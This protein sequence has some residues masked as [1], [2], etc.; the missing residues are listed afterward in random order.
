MTPAITV[1]DDITVDAAHLRGL[2]ATG[3]G[4]A[5]MWD[6]HDV[7]A[8]PA[9]IAD[10]GA[11]FE[12][13]YWDGLTAIHD[14]HARRGQPADSATIAADITG[15]A[16]TRLSPWQHTLKKMMAVTGPYTTALRPHG[17]HRRQ[18]S[19]PAPDGHQITTAYR[20]APTGATATVTMPYYRDA[21]APHHDHD[22][23]PATPYRRPVPSTHP[24]PPPNYP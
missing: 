2:M 9:D 8:A 18:D 1:T 6:G 16:R 13:I 15:Q 5:L 24:F 22:H 17:I 10:H 11:V 12:I 21:I 7:F 14:A 23:R 3:P 4:W 20:I 19:H